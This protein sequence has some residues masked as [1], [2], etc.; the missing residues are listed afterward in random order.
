[1]KR[2]QEAAGISEGRDK[3][4]KKLR[5]LDAAVTIEYEDI[6]SK[7]EPLRHKIAHLLKK[8]D[9]RDFETDKFIRQLKG[10]CSK[11]EAAYW[12][13]L[14]DIKD[15][16]IEHIGIEDN[17]HLLEFCKL[18]RETLKNLDKCYLAVFAAFLEAPSPQE[19]TGG[20]REGDC[21]CTC[22]E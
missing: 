7:Q 21:F 22:E 1:M 14:C 20:K 2:S 19:A 11:Y 8:P 10:I 3:I 4:D 13:L 12:N 9:F 6:L 15:G 17:K 18:G 16:D 5:L